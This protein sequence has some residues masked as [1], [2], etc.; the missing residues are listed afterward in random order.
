[1]SILRISDN[2]IVSVSA[3]KATPDTARINREFNAKDKR[4][5]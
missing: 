2:W 1:M 5:S 3:M 4:Q